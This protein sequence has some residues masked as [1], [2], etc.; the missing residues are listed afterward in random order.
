MCMYIIIESLQ[1]T[2]VYTALH[3][4]DVLCVFCSFLSTSEAQGC[5]ATLQKE[6]QN[7][8]NFTTLMFINL[9]VSR[10]GSVI[11]AF[12]CFS[13]LS[14]GNYTIKVQEIEC[15]GGLGLRQLIHNH[16]GVGGIMEDISEG[17]LLVITSG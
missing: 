2:H 6:T 7:N 15:T 1:R 13:G 9:T 12:D 4:P 8:H 11:E 5:Q 10:E 16:V 3:S 14:A 17:N